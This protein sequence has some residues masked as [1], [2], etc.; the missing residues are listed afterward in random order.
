M[1]LGDKASDWQVCGLMQVAAGAT[2]AAGMYGFDFY[3]AALNTTGRFRLSGAGVGAGGNASGTM[4][5]LEGMGFSPWSSIDCDEPFSINDLNNCWGRLSSLSVGVGVQVGVVY[6][7]AAPRFWSTRTYFHSQNVGG[8]GTGLGA[9]GILI[10]GGWHFS[11]V[12][13]NRPGSSGSDSTMA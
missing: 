4:L 8:L 3:S 7:S 5:P 11:N 1:G 10:I 13:G 2:L 6:I 9:G 12:S